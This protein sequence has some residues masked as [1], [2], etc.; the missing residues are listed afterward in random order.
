MSSA[1]RISQQ[2]EQEQSRREKGKREQERLQA[3]ERLQ[4]S[5]AQPAAAPSSTTLALDCDNED[6]VKPEKGPLNADCHN[7]SSQDGPAAPVEDDTNSGCGRPDAP[8]M[9]DPQGKTL[10]DTRC[11][12][13]EAVTDLSV[14]L[15]SARDAS[16]HDSSISQE[17]QTETVIVAAGTEASGGE[18]EPEA[19]TRDSTADE[20]CR[21]RDE[22]DLECDGGA[23]GRGTGGADGG[24]AEDA[25]AVKNLNSLSGS[26]VD[27]LLD[28][29][30][31]DKSDTEISQGERRSRSNRSQWG[32][33]EEDALSHEDT[34][35]GVNGIDGV[36]V[37]SKDEDAEQ[38]CILS[39]AVSRMG[40][41]EKVRYSTRHNRHVDSRVDVM[42]HTE[43]WLYQPAGE[44][45]RQWRRHCSTQLFQ[46]TCLH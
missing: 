29:D 46:V 3:N 10:G 11:G 1:N 7:S 36:D 23:T 37:C 17:D 31:S 35:N 25:A 12:G 13:P 39:W 2:W 28:F 18:H 41:L 34:C 32:E 9:V 20:D 4:S 15:G 24:C 30:T 42:I 19:Q 22:I 38:A 27:H 6:E 45:G 43:H 16:A 26:T 33:D 8:E 40:M 14:E 21:R 44:R 5:N